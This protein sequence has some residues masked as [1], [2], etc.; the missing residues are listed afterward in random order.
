MS[1]K[2]EAVEVL[3]KHLNQSVGELQELEIF[4][5]KFEIKSF[6]DGWLFQAHATKKDFSPM[7]W[8]VVNG[9]VHGFFFFQ[10][11]NP[12]AYALAKSQSEMLV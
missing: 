7:W 12:R 1:T 2:D 9:G 6:K 4:C 11:A 8:M 10:M 5:A 3:A